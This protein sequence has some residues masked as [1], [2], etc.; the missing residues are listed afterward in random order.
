LRNGI[1]VKSLMNPGKSSDEGKEKRFSIQPLRSFLPTR[2]VPMRF[3][4][5]LARQTSYTFAVSL[6]SVLGGQVA[7][8]YGYFYFYGYS[9]IHKQTSLLDILPTTIVHTLVWILALASIVHYVAFGLP[10]MF[11][12]RGE[13]TRL[14]II[15]D[16]VH[17]MELKG[18]LSSK[19]LSGLL[20]ALS[21]FPLWNTVTAGILGL[22]LLLVLLGVV[23]LHGAGLDSVFLGIRAG[24]IA[25]LVYLYIT[26]VIS[27]F[28]TLPLRSQVK[29]TIHGRGERFETLHLFSLRGKFASFVVFMLITLVVINSFALGSHDDPTEST[30]ISL[31]SLLS[32]LICSFLVGLYFS[33]IYR[34]IE[35]ARSASQELASGGPGYVFSGSLDREFIMLNESMIA[36][37]EE[38]NRYRS[39]MEDLVRQKTQDLEKSLDDLHVSERRFRSMVENGSDL[40]SILNPDGTRKYMSPSVE[41]VLGYKR[42]DFAGKTVFGYVHP[43]DLAR[44]RE[45]FLGV[46]G[47]PETTQKIEYR[48]RHANGSWRDVETIAKS[49][50]HDPAVGGIVINSRDVTDRKRAEE[51]LRITQSS[52]DHASDPVFWMGGDAHLIYVNEAACRSLGYSREE[53]LSMTVHDIDRNLPPEV[54]K[55]HWE[56]IR[57]RGSFTIESLHRAKGGR[58]FP[59]EMTVNY[60]RFE[61]K[62]YNC[63]FAR[64][65][66]ERK[67]A[68][69][70]L[71]KAHQEME[72][73]NQQLEQAIK[74]ANLLTLKA[75]VASVAKS[76]FLANMSHEIRTPMNGVIGMTGLL[77]ETDLS[78]EQMEYTR[79]IHASA[80]ALLSL[81]ND[82][83]D[84]SK[85]E[86]GQ[87]E[88]EVLDFDLRATVEDVTD[89]LAMR[90]NDKGLEFSLLIHPDVPALVRGDPGRIRQI[91]IN[92]TGN[93]VK[94]TEQGE[95]HIRVAV[96]EENEH[97]ATVRFSVIDTGIGIPSDSQDRLFKSFSQVDAS[98]TRKYGGTGLGLAISKQLVE[99]MGGQIGLESEEGR[100]S[101]FWFTVDLEK[102][103]G[104]RKPER[105]LPE[106]I[107]DARILIVDDHATNRLV[108]REMLRSWG[109]RFEEA[110]DGLR[111]LEA[112]EQACKQGDP[113]RIALIDMQM[114]RMD[115]KTLGRKIKE[116]AEIAATRLVMLTSVGSR[117]ETAELQRI[118][119]SA[120][121]TKPIKISQLYDC[122]VTVMGDT[123]RPSTKSRRPIITRHTLREEKKRRVRILVAEDNVVNQKV[124]LRILQTLGYRADAVADGRE[125]V[126]ALETI[127]YDLVL[128]DVQMPEMNGFE[129]TQ[130]IRDPE[131]KVRRHDI[132]IIAMTAHALKGDRERCLEAGMNDY[133]SKPVTALAL[134]ELLDNALA[135]EPSAALIALESDSQP[136]KAVH[137]Q[138]IQA[139]ADGDMGFERD[140]VESYL[141]NTE[142]HLKALE[143]SVHEGAWEEVE[144]WAHT[145]KGSSANAGAKGMQ[146]I[147]R[148]IEEV[149]SS[150]PPESGTL[151]LD[152]IRSEFE[153]VRR[154]FKAYL[155]S[156][157]SEHADHGQ[158]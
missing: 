39:E 143:S 110:S 24:L 151:L 156:R 119:F 77:M 43:D 4:G 131:S 120:Y 105:V 84:F 142:Q 8:L 60:L 145:I 146:E 69:T 88:L 153:K 121:L 28:L 14:R 30:I 99:M 135:A 19:E 123:P 78:P 51:A 59:V 73:T 54:W 94:F 3:F 117:G 17:G 11:G 102:Q 81:I 76:E 112:L 46:L 12:R 118:G 6:L 29:K 134:K 37:A 50:V 1:F 89:M 106:D 62:E 52:I 63:A 144:R 140:L 109:C 49:C 45:A 20:Q 48:V 42:E 38:V 80:D 150:E 2:M 114:P 44:V 71:L 115:G 158:P 56:E 148:R 101:T 103:P 58:E 47:S 157:P 108:F 34:H 128:M 138:R 61:D 41:R 152:E 132:P 87:V 93:A 116:D 122:L 113:F 13:L 147:A 139:I 74:H 82:I 53:L 68:E 15:N 95:V 127:P 125:A 98:I 66:T 126:T 64:D 154:Y 55:G 130:V 7:S 26:Y 25:L 85:I 21:R 124:A 72:K 104:V 129:A 83:L 100:G 31:F 35:E 9:Y 92:L 10:R 149:A 36:A 79:T 57:N 65:I 33:S 107:R 23:M 91:L 32:L 18:T 111:A 141:S 133:L 75:E 155:S 22:S 40:I 86:A 137:I 5:W 90:A 97:Q 27:D 136:G 67:Q 96:D 70:E 16:H